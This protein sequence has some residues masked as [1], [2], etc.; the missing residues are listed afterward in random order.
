M[1]L[2][3]EIKESIGNGNIME[4]IQKAASGEGGNIADQLKSMA[5]KAGL[6]AM[7]AKNPQLASM[8]KG[9][10]TTQIQNI[11]A[12]IQKVGIPKSI[13]EAKALIEKFTNK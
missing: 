9:V 11:V 10:D 12:E 7:I 13:D 3:D 1:G 4:Q 8:L 5:T 2:F 6:E